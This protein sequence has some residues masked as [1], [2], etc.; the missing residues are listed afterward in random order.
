MGKSDTYLSDIYDKFKPRGRVALLG[1]TKNQFWSCAADYYDR[2][3]NN[4]DINDEWVL[5]GQYDT[6]ICTRCAYFAKDPV[7]FMHRLRNHLMPTGKFFV[8]WGRGDHW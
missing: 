6:I 7:A 4:W 3:L 1:A 8:D 5:N 2:Q